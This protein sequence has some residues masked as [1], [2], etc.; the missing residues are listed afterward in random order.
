MEVIHETD[1]VNLQEA[2]AGHHG[3]AGGHLGERYLGGRSKT[4]SERHSYRALTKKSFGCDSEW[5]GFFRRSM[6]PPLRLKNPLVSRLKV[7]AG[8][9]ILLSDV[10]REDGRIKL[11]MGLAESWIP[12]FSAAYLIWWEQK[13]RYATIG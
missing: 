13:S 6:S 10:T 12:C 9:W 8:G 1:D 4:A 11:K 3:S 2:S 7:M 5:T